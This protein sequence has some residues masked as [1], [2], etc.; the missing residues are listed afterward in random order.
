[1]KKNSPAQPPQMTIDQLLEQMEEP[2]AEPCLNC[3]RFLRICKKR[4]AEIAA[5]KLKLAEQSAF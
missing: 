4:D 2:T 3:Q 5:L 1:M